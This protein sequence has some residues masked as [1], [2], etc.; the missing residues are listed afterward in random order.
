M[1]KELKCWSCP[2]C[3]QK[4]NSCFQT[5]NESTPSTLVAPNT[6]STQS[7]AT[8]FGSELSS[9]TPEPVDCS[10]PK[11]SRGGCSKSAT[12]STKT[13]SSTKKE[14]RP[15]SQ[16]ALQKLGA[17]KYF[18][19]LPPPPSQKSLF[20]PVPG[21]CALHQTVCM[22]L[23]L[24]Y[25]AR[26]H[27]HWKSGLEKDN[28]P[29]TYLASP[30]MKHLCS[31]FEEHCYRY[32]TTAGKLHVNTVR[33]SEMELQEFFKFIMEANQSLRIEDKSD[34]EAEC[35]EAQHTLAL[36]NL[37]Q[38]CLQKQAKAILQA[39]SLDSE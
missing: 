34:A 18:Q 6:Q 7:G 39:Y 20:D 17:A 19:L 32:G 13:K 8:T 4:C 12:G 9:S 29:P 1:Q 15:L 5:K 35:K 31:I 25:K 21:Q 26:H 14:Y 16:E 2:L 22:R 38:I 27:A 33:E 24:D 30:V 3:N 28:R 36:A 10:T 11:P 23:S 37:S